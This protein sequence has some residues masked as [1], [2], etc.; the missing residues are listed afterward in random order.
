MRTFHDVS[1]GNIA[2]C[3]RRRLRVHKIRLE[4]PRNE[5]LLCIMAGS[6]GLRWLRHR[7]VRPHT[8]DHP[9]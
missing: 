5:V 3:A 9:L 4:N 2:A 6:N 7:P 8:S 1:R